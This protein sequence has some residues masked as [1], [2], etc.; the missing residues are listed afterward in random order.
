[1]QQNVEVIITISMLFKITITLQHSFIILQFINS[2]CNLL[3]FLTM[4]QQIRE[5]RLIRVNFK[6]V[7]LNG[8]NYT[9]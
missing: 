8:S 9:Y 2:A 3:S 4:E 1:M 6:I 7:F 5:P